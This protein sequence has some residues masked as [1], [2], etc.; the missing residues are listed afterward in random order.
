MIYVFDGTLNGLLTCVFTY[1]V[2]KPGEQ[3]RVDEKKVQPSMF[4]YTQSVSTDI[5]AAERVWKG[6]EKKANAATLKN[7]Y[8]A[9][10]S[11]DADIYQH[12]F[13]LARYIFDVPAG[14]FMDFGNPHVLA[15]NQM[16]RS[17]KREKH[18]MEAFI[19]FEKDSS[20]LFFAVIKPD[21][22]VLPLIIRH[23]RSRYADQRWLIYDEQRRYGVYYDL[24]QVTE[25]EID[26]RP[27]K[28]NQPG[29]AFD[30]EENL[31]A[32][33]WKAYFDSTN[34][35]ERKNM[36]LHLQHVPRRYWRYLTEK[37]IG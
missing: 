7:F 12:L 10:L 16:V 6:L 36:K 25:V 4:E 23:F 32:T 19:R 9:F 34:I 31:Y 21:F 24:N 22:N 5:P 3:V 2:Q 28:S 27:E 29:M 37:K 11:G 14:S 20:G 35:K 13:E 15:V 26:F 30:A 33:L 8:T 1:Y 17:V 18:R